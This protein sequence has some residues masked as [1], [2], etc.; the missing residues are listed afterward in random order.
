MILFVSKKFS[1]TKKQKKTKFLLCFSLAGSYAQLTLLGQPKVNSSLSQ[2]AI[3]ADNSN[4]RGQ[5]RTNP[6]TSSVPERS[7]STSNTHVL[8]TSADTKKLKE[9]YDRISKQL[10]VSLTHLLIS[11]FSINCFHFFS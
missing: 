5:L 4:G 2:K 3:P 8:S 9:N 1:E 6:P 10:D 7:N 11:I